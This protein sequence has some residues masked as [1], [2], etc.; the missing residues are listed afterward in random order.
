MIDIESLIFVARGHRVILDSDLAILY[1][2]TTKRLNEQVRRNK[3]RFPD[4]FMFQMEF[5][6][7]SCLRS[8][9]ATSKGG[10][11]YKP[12]AFTE[13]GAIMVANV[14]NSEIAIKA[15]IMLVRTFIKMRTLFAEH[16]ELKKRLVDVEKRLAHGFTQHEQELLEIRYLISQLEKP[17]ETSKKRMGFYKR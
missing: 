14:L 9:I 12:Y 2:T 10:R 1:G 4:D 8:Q 17:I 11:R 13:H 15:S 7:V 5:Q 16:V 6:E 3:D